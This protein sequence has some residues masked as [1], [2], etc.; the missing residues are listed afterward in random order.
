MIYVDRMLY[1]YVYMYIYIYVNHNTYDI[2][3]WV[4]LRWVRAWIWGV[5]QDRLGIEGFCVD[6][7]GLC[8]EFHR[9]LL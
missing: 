3:G 6:S 8:S 5:S 4:W 9:S 7:S 2:W 1:L